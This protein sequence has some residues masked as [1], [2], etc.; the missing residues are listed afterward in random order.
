M[1][2]FLILVL[3]LLFG[4]SYANVQ[5]K[6]DERIE[7]MSI[8]FRLAGNPEYSNDNN[9]KYVAEIETYFSPYKNN[10][11]I[12]YAKSLRKNRGISYD[13]VMSMAIHLEK[14]GK[15]FQLISEKEDNLDSRWQKKKKKK[16]II[17]L[18]EFYHKTKF[19]DFFEQH[20]SDYKY[21]EN[22]FSENLNVFDE[23]WYSQFYGQTP[24]EDFKILIGYGNGGGNYGP[25]VE[26]NNE[27]KIVYAILGVWKFDEVGN[28]I[29]KSDDYASTLIHEFNHSFVNPVLEK[30]Y[31]N[32][33]NLKSAGEK[34]LEEQ[35][36]I[37]KDQAYGNWFTVI[38][39]SLVRASVIQY[40]IDHHLKPEEIEDEIKI[41]EFRGF[42]WTRNL[43][44][45]LNTYKNQRDQYKTFESFYP[46]IV[47]FFE[48]ESKNV[49]ATKASFE[50]LIP[51]ITSLEPFENNAQ[52]VDVNTKQITI[53]FSR[54]ML[55]NG[56]SLNLGAL[57]K[58][59][60]PIGKEV[61]FEYFNNNQSLKLEFIDLKPDTEYEFLLTG[62][63]FR[64]DEGYPLKNYTIKFKT[65]K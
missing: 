1:K 4:Y 55:G 14:K 57:G 42:I 12:L 16:F 49:K 26:L 52:N 15:Y 63:R 13:A 31:F 38:N 30:K 7:L 19:N 54:K 18:N 47:D 25:K 3:F 20:S 9:K 56:V 44:N 60:V 22:S 24:Q 27:K 50:N 17:L 2:H 58:D 29:I 37:M 41:Q 64:S 33:Q 6:V 5:P 35:K 39:E 48:E 59:H 10:D 46:K 51:T 45:L 40:M 62:K 34:L 53:N 61:K 11:L 21:V 43:V 23:N 32:N 36:E 28:P 8:V 65:S